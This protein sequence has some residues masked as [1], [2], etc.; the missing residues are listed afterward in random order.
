MDTENTDGTLY[1]KSK[2]VSLL[3]LAFTAIVCSKILFFFFNDLEGPNLIVGAGFSLFLFF[4]SWAAYVFS[5]TKIKGIRRLSAAICLQLLLVIG[6][7]F[8]MR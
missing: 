3:I 4:L 8:F 6:L 1:F 2:K 5:P 7:Y